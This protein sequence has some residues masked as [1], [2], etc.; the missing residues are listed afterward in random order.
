MPDIAG[1]KNGDV[2]L[3]P[4]QLQIYEKD[5]KLNQFGKWRFHKVVCDFKPDIIFAI[6]DHWMD[7]WMLKSP[8]RSFFKFT[9]MPTIDRIATR[10]KM[11]S[12]L[13]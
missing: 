2:F 12:R 4:E 1:L 6:R 10:S 13:F 11:A 5:Y 7:E 9:W 8:Y 3:N